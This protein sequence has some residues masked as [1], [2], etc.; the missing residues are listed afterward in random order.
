MGI[1]FFIIGA[2]LKTHPPVI[3]SHPPPASKV[4]AA[5]IYIYVCFYS[6]GW[7]KLNQNDVSNTKLII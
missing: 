3:A 6:A 2:V 5:L 7:G 1:L 4:M